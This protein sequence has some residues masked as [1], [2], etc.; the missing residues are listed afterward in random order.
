MDERRSLG[1]PFC[2]AW[3]LAKQSA[4]VPLVGARTR[5]QVADVLG[6]LERP[7]AADEVAEVEA[8]VSP[9]MVEGT[10]YP[11]AAMKHLDSER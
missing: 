11:E 8:A 5:E 1:A 10:R 2:V 4:L 6:A 7:L 3:A 9:E